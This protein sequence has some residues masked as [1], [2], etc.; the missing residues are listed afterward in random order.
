[1]LQYTKTSTNTEN[2]QCDNK[3]M[4][5][6]GT[7][8]D[9]FWVAR[10]PFQ[11]TSPFHLRSGLIAG[12]ET[13]SRRK[14]A[15]SSLQRGCLIRSWSSQPWASYGCCFRALRNSW[16][17][18]TPRTNIRWSQHGCI[19]PFDPWRLAWRDPVLVP[20]TRS[21][22]LWLWN[23]TT[24]SGACMNDPNAW[25][26]CVVPWSI[27]TRWRKRLWGRSL[28]R[29]LWTSSDYGASWL[30]SQWRVYSS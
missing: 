5:L 3:S 13:T 2:S 21:S 16:R 1:M 23:C 14:F 22:L 7:D 8:R 4:L 19:S 26:V 6:K 29:G 28:L 10:L 11:S 30:A 12:S 18:L 15:S 25:V 24:N 27:T 9:F 17:R 20:L